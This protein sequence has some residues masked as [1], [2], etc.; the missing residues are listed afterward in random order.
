MARNP[1]KQK[2][3]VKQEITLIGLIERFHSPD[4]CRE[5]LEELRWPDKLACLRC[6][7][8]S[9]SRIHTRDQL[10]CNSCRYR[11]SVTTGTIFHDT[12]LPLWKWFLAVYT[13]VESKKGVS[14][15]QLKRELGVSYK[16][17]WYLSH[18]IRNAMAQ[19]REDTEPFDG[20]V[21]VD[22]TFVGGK[23]EGQ[24]RG[25]KGNKAL[26]VGMVQYGGEIVLRIADDRTRKTLHEIV[27][28]Q[29]DPKAVAIFT[30]EWPAY[31]GIGDHDTRHETVN[32]SQDEY[33][34]GEVHTNTI[35]GVWSLLKR[36]IIG[37]FHHVSIKHLDAYLDELEWRFSNRENPFMF[38]DTMQELVKAENL[39]YKELT[40]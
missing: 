25:Y 11:F 37:A 20:I 27:L 39:E 35:E 31:A 34:R 9:V 3:E 36:S 6:G 32:H 26:V 15:N 12:H 17:A 21:E 5:Y 33:V 40:A 29:T 8:T 4:T 28:K 2:P 18:R 22:E 7:S 10:D 23:T 16:T 38:G 14:S 19:A 30:D 13:I 1:R 24:G